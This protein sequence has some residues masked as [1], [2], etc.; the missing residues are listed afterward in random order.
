MTLSGL[1]LGSSEPYRQAAAWKNHG[2]G[3]QSFLEVAEACGLE[4]L[5]PSKHLLLLW[6]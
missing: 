6:V 1:T 4:V 2:P 3:R 5:W